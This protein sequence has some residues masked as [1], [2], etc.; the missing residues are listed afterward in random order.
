MG[1][2]GA[3]LRWLVASGIYT[4]AEARAL[5]TGEPLGERWLS[6]PDGKQVDVNAAIRSG[7]IVS[8][9]Q[10]GE[11]E[12]VTAAGDQVIGIAME[13][14]PRY[15]VARVALGVPELTQAQIDVLTTGIE[16]FNI[17][18]ERGEVIIGPRLPPAN[19]AMMGSFA[20]AHASMAY[21]NMDYNNYHPRD[22]LGQRMDAALQNRYQHEDPAKKEANEK[23]WK[24]LDKYM[25][26]DQYFAFME[27]TTVELINKKETH[28]L[29]INRKG[30]FTI[31]QGIKAGAGIT[32]ASGRIHSY[33]YPLG[34]QISAFLDWFRHRTGELVANWNCGTFGI[35]QKGKRR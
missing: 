27:G 25:T 23:A 26:P 19:L 24:L 34:D 28:R 14:T 18:E 29:L 16:P 2:L 10:D 22:R 3:Y 4:I 5:I 30:D 8:F 1:S 20:Y 33:E 31:L 12:K 17:V 32:E 15:G 6:T 7:D 13:D 35:V 21:G 11:L 9:N